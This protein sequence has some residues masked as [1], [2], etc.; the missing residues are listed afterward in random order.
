MLC[1]QV[2]HQQVNLRTAALLVLDAYSTAA[3]LL[4][5]LMFFWLGSP[6]I[7]WNLESPI[8]A[9]ICKYAY[10][11]SWA[12]VVYQLVA[13]NHFELFGLAQVRHVFRCLVSQK[14]NLLLQTLGRVHIPVVQT[15]K[16]FEHAQLPHP[17]FLP[18]VVLLVAVP[19]M[20]FDRLILAVGAAVYLLVRN[21]VRPADWTR[22]L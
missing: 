9:S 13:L 6:T 19:R 5:I 7:V 11:I 12:I 22:S 18:W 1:V 21:N 4:E 14:T 2:C 16:A 20:S 15:T 17:I 10:P 3:A 8:V